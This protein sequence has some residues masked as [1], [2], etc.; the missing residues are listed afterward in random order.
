MAPGRH[1]AAQVLGPSY[2]QETLDWVSGFH[3][4]QHQLLHYYTT[5]LF[6][7]RSRLKYE[8]L[9]K[10]EVYQHKRE[11]EIVKQCVLQVIKLYCQL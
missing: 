5:L 6:N 9:L 8:Q 7:I 2:L 10:N 4:P 11:A 1:S 3:L